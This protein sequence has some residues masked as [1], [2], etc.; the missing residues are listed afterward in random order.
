[1]GTGGSREIDPLRFAYAIAGLVVTIFGI[2]GWILPFV[3]GLPLVIIGLSML[4][5]I[6]PAANR[7]ADRLRA[8]SSTSLR[9]WFARPASPQEIRREFAEASSLTIVDKDHV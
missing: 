5:T 8:R 2:I 4:A 6:H 1:M 9:R 3:P 7:W